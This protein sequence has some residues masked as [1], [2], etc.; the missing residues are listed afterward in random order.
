MRAAEKTSSPRRGGRPSKEQAGRIEDEILD[1]AAGLFFTEGY[2]ATSIEAIARRARISKRTFYHR[3]P[4]KAAVFKAVVKRVIDRL[5]PPQGTPQLFEGK[6]IEEILNRLARLILRA[7]MTPDALA[8]HRVILAE[9]VRFPELAV[10][11]G[12]QGARQEA[13]QR[14]AGL[15]QREA[16]AGHIALGNTVFAAEQFLQMVVGLPQRRALGLGISMTPDELD[17]WAR[18]TVGLFL[19]GCRK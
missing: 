13:V 15:L 5:R 2:G 18:D 3:F 6:S 12:D 4:D 16:N 8:L 19:K 17:V 10:I 7:A 9:A 11:I 14:I 1:A